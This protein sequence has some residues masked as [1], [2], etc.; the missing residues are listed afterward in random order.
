MPK[1]ARVAH[2]IGGDEWA[3]L[4][5]EVGGGGYFYASH[6]FPIYKMRQ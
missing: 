1:W 2:S 3:V 5:W 6:S 4:F